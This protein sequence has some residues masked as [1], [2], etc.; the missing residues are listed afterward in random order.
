M[1]VQRE[2]SLALKI[3]LQTSAQTKKKE[4]SRSTKS[5]EFVVK[6]SAE[7]KNKRWPNFWNLIL[8]KYLAVL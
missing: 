1:P 2:F 4:S 7:M 5:S 6:L 3:S 8:W